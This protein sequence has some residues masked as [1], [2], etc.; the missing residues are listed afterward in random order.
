VQQDEDISRALLNIK[1]QV[2]YEL[3]LGR[4]EAL[5]AFN[6]GIVELA[7]LTSGFLMQH[8]LLCGYG[9]ASSPICPWRIYRTSVEHH[10]WK[11]LARVLRSDGVHTFSMSSARTQELNRES[12][13]HPMD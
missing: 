3:L 10:G 8:S 12:I 4:H 7:D 1:G 9:A 13:D 11:W 2:V 6:D 5:G